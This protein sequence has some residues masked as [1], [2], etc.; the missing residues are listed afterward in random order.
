MRFV[1]RQSGSGTR[2]LF[3]LLCA[4]HGVD[5]HAIDGY[6]TLEFTHAS[7]AAHVGSGMADAGL[8]LEVP[9][10]RF[11]LDFVPLATDRYFFLCR[12]ALLAEPKMARIV[13]ALR[14]PVLRAEIGALPGYDAARAGQVEPARNLFGQHR[15]RVTR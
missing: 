2:L 9:A 5:V 15:R 13:A 8:G 10:R 7:V 3:D 1:N 6:E 14:D 11:R 12:E 4:Q